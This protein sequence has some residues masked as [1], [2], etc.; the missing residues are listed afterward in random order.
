MDNV[1]QEIKKDKKPF[2][3]MRVVLF[4]QTTLTL[5]TKFYKQCERGRS[6]K[7]AVARGIILSQ[8]CIQPQLP[9]RDDSV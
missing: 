4:I 2:A 1:R 7:T 5:F 8:P 9:R 6:W 3:K